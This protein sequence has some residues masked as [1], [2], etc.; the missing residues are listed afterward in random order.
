MPETV[1][2]RLIDDEFPMYVSIDDDG[3]MLIEWD[4]NHPAT[5]VFNDWKEEDF[6]DA[7]ME[8]CKHVLG[9]E[10]YDRINKEYLDQQ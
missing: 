4:E 10:E 3:T 1:E 5:S 9:Q 6:L 2:S 7:L 8:H